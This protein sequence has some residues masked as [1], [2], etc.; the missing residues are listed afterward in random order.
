[1]IS[2][3][4]DASDSDSVQSNFDEFY[5]KMQCLLDQFYPQRT[6]TITSTDPDFITP[7]IKAQL[8]RKNRLMRAGHVEEAGAIAEQVRR[9]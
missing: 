8:W 1:M 2:S 3:T 9:E 4:I 5:Q 6:V 7:T